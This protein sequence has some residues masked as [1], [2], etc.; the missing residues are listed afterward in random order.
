MAVHCGLYF[1]SFV[2]DQMPGQS[3]HK[4]RKDHSQSAQEAGVSLQDPQQA[5]HRGHRD[6][7]TV[8]QHRVLQ[9]KS[10]RSTQEHLS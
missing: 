8:K 4:L 5:R 7:P 3:S 6:G 2:S 1:R 10:K 9:S